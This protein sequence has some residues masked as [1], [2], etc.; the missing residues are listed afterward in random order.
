MSHTDVAVV[1][2]K[3]TVLGNNEV[4]S[5]WCAK[6]DRWNLYSINDICLQRVTAAGNDRRL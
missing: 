3:R 5:Q 2:T 1:K 4:N 6:T